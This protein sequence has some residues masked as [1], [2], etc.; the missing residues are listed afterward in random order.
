MPSQERHLFG[1][2]RDHNDDDEERAENGVTLELREET[3]R[4]RKDTVEAGHV[5]IGKEVVEETRTVQ[6]PLTREEVTIDRRPVNRRPSDEPISDSDSADVI[7]VPVHEEEVVVE[8]Q[9]V[10][11]D[12]VR[13]GKRTVQETQRVSDAVR[14]EVIDVDATG[15]VDVSDRR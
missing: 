2:H 12:E 1:E 9:P 10:V 11:Y 8:K 5:S 6:V 15:D 3:L 7:N 4:A 13:L 14:K